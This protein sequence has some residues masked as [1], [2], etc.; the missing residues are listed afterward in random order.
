MIQESL[1]VGI[2]IERR[3]EDNKWIDHSWHVVDAIAGAPA[4][5]A[6]LELDRG[7]RS[8][9]YHAAT[10]PIEIFGG[11]TEGYKVNLSLDPPVIFVVIDT[12]GMDDGEAPIEICH[13]TVCPYEAQD[14]L[15]ASENIVET[16]PMPPAVSA[17]LAAFVE[18]HH[19]DKPFKKRKREP[20]PG[21]QDAPNELILPPAR[22]SERKRDR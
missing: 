10:L 9:R 2:V 17:W 19:V 6:W 7:E 8:V 22:R 5:D 11:E 15:D 13:A 4:V 21:K 16:V 12:E 3:D 14:Y 1:N 18:A 20:H